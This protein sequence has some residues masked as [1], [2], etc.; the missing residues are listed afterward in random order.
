VGEH[1]FHLLKR[2]QSL[3]VEFNVF[4]TK[5]IELV[6]QCFA[7]ESQAQE[8]GFQSYMPKLDLATGVLSVVETNMFKQLTHISLQLRP[9]N[10]AAIKAYLASR[11]SLTLAMNRRMTK[12]LEGVQEI[13]NVA[14]TQK[15]EIANEL[16]E[17]RTHKDVEQKTLKSQHTQEVSQMQM[18][19]MSNMEQMREKYE[20]QLEGARSTI[21]TLQSAA[22]VKADE[23]L[24][25]T[26]DLQHEKG[27]LEF[28]ERELMRLL[29]SADADRDRISHECKETAV[30]KRQVEEER[31]N[32]ERELARSGAK[33]E[34]L[35]QQVLD[36]DEVCS[37]FLLF[38]SLL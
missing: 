32:L 15:E 10:D 30:Q 9:G 14:E 38:A 19:M 11:L 17:I 35:L 20:A 23:V 26:T 25:L 22:K 33:V 21:D 6:E 5:L 3:L 1:D 27:H 18:T 7:A 13:L 36:R 31:G 16:Q 34:A 4:P 2:D 29:E 12:D 28:R 8:S 37:F 24:K